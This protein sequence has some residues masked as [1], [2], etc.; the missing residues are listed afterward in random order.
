MP[1][2]SKAAASK[3]PSANL[4][5]ETKL[6]LAADNLRNNMDA[7]EPSEA[8]QTVR[9]TARRVSEA[10]QYKAGNGFRVPVEGRWSHL[11]ASARL[12]AIG[13][14]VDDAMV[15]IQRDNPRLKG[16]LPRDYARPG[17]DTAR[18]DSALFPRAATP[19]SLSAAKDNQRLG[20]R[21][22]VVATIEFT[23][24]SEGEKTPGSV[25]LLGREADCLFCRSEIGGGRS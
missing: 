23:A 25:D 1:A 3:D 14:L 9:S 11:Q 12:P 21:I 18:H 24:A 20:E 2:K 17:F 8:R 10:K 22:N 4:G 13:K 19:Q 6:W 15:A 5:F 16:V 7:P